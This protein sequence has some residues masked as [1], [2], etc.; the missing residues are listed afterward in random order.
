[1]VSRALGAGGGRL[2]VNV[3]GNG[4]VFELGTDDLI[5]L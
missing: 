2:F 4:E 5:C 1:M 3:L